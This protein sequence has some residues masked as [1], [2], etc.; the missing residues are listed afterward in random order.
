MMSHNKRYLLKEY[1]K[2]RP[3]EYHIFLCVGGFKNELYC[4]L[5]FDSLYF[6][7]WVLKRRVKEFFKQVLE[8]LKIN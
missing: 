2:E 6:R 8:L 1:M 4:D 7:L 5:L 3:E